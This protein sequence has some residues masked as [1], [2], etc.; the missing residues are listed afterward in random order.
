MRLTQAPLSVRLPTLARSYVQ[1]VSTNATVLLGYRIDEQDRCQSQ[2]ARSGRR[3]YTSKSG[4]G[5]RVADEEPWPCAAFDL[6]LLTRG[7]KLPFLKQDMSRTL[8]FAGT[9][10]ES[11]C[12]S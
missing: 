8:G 6:T 4:V 5:P 2:T 7:S 3:L 11:A 1:Q 12:A 10:D 9:A